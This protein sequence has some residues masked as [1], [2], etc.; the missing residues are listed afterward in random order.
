VTKKSLYLVSTPIGNLD[1]I[2]LRAI[3][4]LKKS[5]YIL[6]EDTR[7]SKNLLN[8][9]Q[10]QSKLIS[11]HKFN[12]KKNLSKIIEFIK[13]G[14]FVSLI[15]DA[16]TPSISDPG[17]ILI[18][19]CI[20]NNIE[21]IPLPGASAVTTALSI[22]GFSEKFFFYGFFPEKNKDLLNDLESLS[23]LNSSLVFFISPKKLNKIIPFIKKNFK[24][25]KILICREMTKFYEEFYRF[26]I[27]DLELFK[28]NLKGEL[29]IVISEKNEDKKISQILNESDKRIINKMI[30]K[31]SVKEISS[32]INE[33]NKIPKKVIY[34]YC[35]TIKNEK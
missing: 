30:N 13:Q 8:K 28:S 11:N 29:T 31:L 24:G 17:A 34:D 12:E 32:I 6:C 2:S 23:Q 10:I 22:S 7:V 3:D 27:D 15:S 21:I 1:D 9:Y 18:K 33:N 25:R 5:D 26:E 20:K 19:E 16:G 14:L 4:I 35:L